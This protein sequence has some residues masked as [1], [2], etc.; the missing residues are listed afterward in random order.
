M[1]DMSSMNLPK[2]LLATAFSIFVF[3]ACAS[4][5]VP[6]IEPDPVVI[7]PLPG[8]NYAY[9]Y[10]DAASVGR[11][12]TRSGNDVRIADGVVELLGSAVDRT[13]RRTAVAFRQE[14]GTKLVVVDNADGTVTDV[15]DGAAGATYTMVWSADGTMLGVGFQGG[16]AGILVMDASGTVHNI[17]C[18]A[19]NRFEAWR[20]A[21]EVVVH[22][23]TN[24]YAVS[25]KDCATLATFRIGAKKGMTYSESGRRVSYFEDR[26]VQFTNRESEQVIAELSIANYN[27]AGP[28]KVADFQSRPSGAILNSEGSR[29]A[30]E[31]V[32]ARWANTTHVVIYE[33]STNEYT[34][35]A[36]EKQLGVPSDFNACWSSNGRTIAHER[37]FARST[38]VQD[39]VSR[40]VVVRNGENEKVVFDEIVD[41][42]LHAFTANRPP[43]CQWIGDRYLLIWSNKGNR[44]IDAEDDTTYEAAEDHRL[45][46]ATVFE[47]TM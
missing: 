13:G 41:R 20:T 8:D 14:T 34:Y 18:S 24:F 35:V 4:A 1:R 27:G 16:D 36:E 9:V 39:Y 26:T 23:G 19:S 5:P 32:S 2:R 43:R 28:T 17:G 40:Q 29:I 7:A 6:D 11:I 47:G 10:H 21:T 38:G 46:G 3:G 31:V 15:Y 12:D 30:Y 42:P 45:L 33:M 25:T 44:I 37:A 22:D